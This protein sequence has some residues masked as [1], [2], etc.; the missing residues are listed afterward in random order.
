[1][2][3]RNLKSYAIILSAGH[4][5]ITVSN[6]GPRQLQSQGNFH[7]RQKKTGIGNKIEHYAMPQSTLSLVKN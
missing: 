7:P 6:G 4:P 3:F 2:Q 1:L 5:G